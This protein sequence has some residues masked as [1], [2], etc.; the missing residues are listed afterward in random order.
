MNPFVIDSPAPPSELIDR[1]AE[2]DQLL[3]MAEGGHNT[4]LSAPRRYGKTT[5]L[6]KLREDVEA[7]GMAAVYVDCFGVLSLAEL[8]ARVDAAYSSGLK[9]PLGTWYGRVRRSWRVRLRAGVPG[10]GADL[11]S[12]A[13]SEAETLLDDLLDLPRRV[14]ERSGRRT[15]VQF[16]EFQDVLAAGD[17]ADAAIRARIQHHRAE[18]AYLFAGSH[19]GLMAELFGDRERPFYGQARPLVL[20]P[21]PEEP[22]GEYVEARF[23]DTG[24][25]PGWA[26]EPLLDLARGHPQRA[27]LLAH[28]LWEAV[29][30]GGAADSDAWERCAEAVMEELNELYERTWERLSVN[31]RRTYTAIAWL[32]PWGGGS[33][34]LAADTLN[35]FMLKKSTA[36]KI[37][38]ELELRGETIVEGG[39]PRLVDPLF[40]VWIASLRRPRP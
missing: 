23:R 10:A 9:G 21:L 33:T 13:A 12:L 18:A 11:E 38:R 32:G 30:P 19:P 28:H 1:E 22:L 31:E 16:D 7:L 35:R 3:R 15:L 20:G 5:L 6:E 17:R 29:P 36:R 2:V 14:H 40:E 24:R 25:D 27:M 34:L 39:R 4:R 37:A 26:I 8:A